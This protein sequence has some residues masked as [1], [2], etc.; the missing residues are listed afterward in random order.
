MNGDSLDQ[1]CSLIK[2]VVRTETDDGDWYAALLQDGS[3]LNFHEMND[4]LRRF[5]FDSG[6]AVRTYV[7]FTGQTIYERRSTIGGETA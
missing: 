6:H 5:I 2:K 7:D 3:W 1:M 4:I